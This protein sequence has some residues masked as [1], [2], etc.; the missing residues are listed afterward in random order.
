[1]FPSFDEPN[2]KATFKIS[3]ENEK[4]FTALSNMEELNVTE[5]APGWTRT[6]FDVTPLMS[7][8]I[9]AFVVSDFKYASTTGPNGLKIRVWTR[10]DLLNNT[11]YALNIIPRGFQFFQDYFNI[12]EVVKKSDHFAAPDLNAGAMEVIYSRII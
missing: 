2:L 8:Y 4:E 9:L 11:E 12:S 1:M 10:E 7:T 5:T 3:I 6:D